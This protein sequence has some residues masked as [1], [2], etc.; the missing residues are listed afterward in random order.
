MLCWRS[1]LYLLQLFEQLL[2]IVVGALHGHNSGSL[3]E[4]RFSVNTSCITDMMNIGSTLEK[5]SVRQAR[6]CRAHIGHDTVVRKSRGH[7]R[8]QLFGRSCADG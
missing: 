3:P 2:G 5:S 7:H 4:A 6:I 1:L 8:K